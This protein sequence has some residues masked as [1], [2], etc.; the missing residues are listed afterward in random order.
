MLARRP[1]H[2]PPLLIRPWALGFQA[3][4]RR[5]NTSP[6]CQPRGPLAQHT[7]FDFWALGRHPKTSVPGPRMKAPMPTGLARSDATPGDRSLT[8]H[9][10]RLTIHPS[11]T[12]NPAFP[13]RTRT[14]GVNRRLH[15]IPP[16]RRTACRIRAGVRNADIGK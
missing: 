2:N 4:P 5:L 7:L 8:N 14:V 3:T 15:P 12:R 6:G 10:S 1:T 16:A 11:D 9:G 13:A